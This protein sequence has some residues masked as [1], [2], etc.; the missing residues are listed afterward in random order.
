MQNEATIWDAIFVREGVVFSHPHEDVLHLADML[1]Q[2]GA[3]RVLD[4]GCGSGRHVLSLCQRGLTV[5]GIDSAPTGIALTQQRLQEAGLSA[6]LSQG[7]IFEGLPFADACFDAVLS[8][9]VIHHALLAQIHGL[10]EEMIR[11]LKPH[12]LIFVTVPQLRNQGTHFQQ[13]EPGTYIPL[14]GREVGLPHHY[15]TPAELR[16]LF[17]PCRLVDLHVDDDHHYCLTAIKDEQR[18]MSAEKQR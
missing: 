7:N 8:V 17:Q 4:V 14:D 12:G 15:F 11:V 3:K 10:A 2:H 5:Y 16:D 18:C 13:V 6:H 9:Q 1:L